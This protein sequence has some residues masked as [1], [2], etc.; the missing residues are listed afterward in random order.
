MSFYPMVGMFETEEKLKEAHARISRPGE[1]LKVESQSF[2]TTERAIGAIQARYP[3]FVQRELNDY[4]MATIKG[5]TR[6][7]HLNDG[8]Y[9][10]WI[11]LAAALLIYGASRTGT[12]ANAMPSRTTTQEG[13]ADGCQMVELEQG[14]KLK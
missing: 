2:S 13:D 6:K 8:L 3:E 9:M 11:V 4:K 7:W 1:T 5:T 14:V 10:M 12:S